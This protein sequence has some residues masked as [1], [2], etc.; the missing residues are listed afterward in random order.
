M[1]NEHHG[2]FEEDKTSN[3][4]VNINNV[5]VMNIKERTPSL[6]ALNL[7]LSYFFTCPVRDTLF[8]NMDPGQVNTVH[9][10]TQ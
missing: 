10:C 3:S 2:V 5:W 1:L 4:T 9:V 7:W 8:I 6:F